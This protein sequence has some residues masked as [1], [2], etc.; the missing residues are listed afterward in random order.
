MAAFVDSSLWP[1]FR[2][3]AHA[4]E[5]GGRGLFG[6][7]VAGL[8]FKTKR[9]ETMPG[10]IMDS[11]ELGWRFVHVDP[12]NN[13]RQIGRRCFREQ[14][15]SVGDSSSFPILS[16]GF[17]LPKVQSRFLDV[18]WGSRPGT[19]RTP[20]TPSPN[21]LPNPPLFRNPMVRWARLAVLKHFVAVDCA[22]AA[23]FGKEL[24]GSGDLGHLGGGGC[25]A[26][27]RGRGGGLG[28]GGVGW[29]LG[30]RRGWRIVG[31][32]RRPPGER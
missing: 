2:P 32:D 17:T 4:A 11:S 15:P 18:C 21:P 10:S 29:K 16:V 1:L 24:L 31:T 14:V 5:T 27:G 7:F 19:L 26:F 13:K 22:V 30:G 25:V 6:W 3:E 12:E 28:G 8:P 9:V 23:V 20:Q